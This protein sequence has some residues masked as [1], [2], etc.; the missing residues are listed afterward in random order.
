MFPLLII[1]SITRVG[2]AVGPRT[3]FGPRYLSNVS[4]GGI[5]EDN[6]LSGAL[7][8]GIAVTSA[9]NFTVENNVLFGNTS[10]IGTKGP[11]CSTTDIVPISAPFVYDNSTSQVTLQTNFQ[12]IPDGNALTCVVA[13]ENGNYW[14]FGN[15]PSSHLFSN[16][17]QSSSSSSS[18]SSKM[19]PVSTA[20]FAL[21]VI[22]GVAA[23][24]VMTWFI[25]KW[26]V[27]RIEDEKLYKSSK[28]LV[29]GRGPGYAKQG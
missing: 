14:P 18:T 1:D 17:R 26:V 4:F 22:T 13:P 24:G 16:A 10:F 11:N 6:R 3:W 19:S 2:I 25:R 9:R 8:Y 23:L 29:A 20:C 27:K 12:L 5:V 15:V 21:G 7:G 28:A